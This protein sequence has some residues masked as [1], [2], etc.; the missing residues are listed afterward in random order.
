[1]LTTL[2]SLYVLNLYDT[3]VLFFNAAGMALNFKYEGTEG[4]LRW[5]GGNF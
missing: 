4:L 1:M 2:P 5:S 3:S